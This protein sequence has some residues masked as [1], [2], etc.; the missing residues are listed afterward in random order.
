MILKIFVFLLLIASAAAFLTVRAWRR[1]PHGRLDTRV[2]ILLKVVALR[3]VDLFG[4]GR[5]PDEIRQFSKKNGAALK[6]RHDW[7]GE[8]RDE[9]IVGGG[10]VVP[11]RRYSSGKE[12]PVPIVIYFHGGGWVMGDL[13]THDNVCR[14]LAKKTG[15]MVISVD[16]RLAP[17][18]PFPAAFD[19]AYTALE[20]VAQN[21]GAMGGDPDRIFV[22]GDSAGANLAAAIC[23]AARDRKGPAI[24]GQALAYPA[25]DLSTFDRSSYQNFAEGYY[26]TRTY[27][28]EFRNRYLPEIEDRSKPYASPLLASN[29][30]HLPP[31]LI[32]TAQFDVLRDEGDAFAGRLGAAGVP[33]LAS[34]YNGM[35]HGFLSMDR[36]LPQAGRATDEIADFVHRLS[37]A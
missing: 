16:Y 19:D 26:L 28:K 10:G 1:T 23:L 31:A 37:A 30:D 13:D 9:T 21:A 14:L 25:T 7:A 24:C 12:T 2:A 27:M 5:S 17:E 20:W 4:E 6:G 8:I 29:L 18:H 22:A 36:L 15:A 35:I 32:I 11:I 33:V 3:K 34:R